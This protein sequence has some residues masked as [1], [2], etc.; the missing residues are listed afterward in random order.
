MHV[1]SVLEAVPHPG[2]KEAHGQKHE[3]QIYPGQRALPYGDI[4][5]DED[6]PPTWNQVV[7]A[8]GNVELQRTAST[9][10]N[11]QSYSAHLG[12]S[13]FNR[14]C[15]TLRRLFVAFIFLDHVV[16]GLAILPF[17]VKR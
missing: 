10:V 16:D 17:V 4:V 15:A 12:L 7:H 8:R 1:L 5:L 9:V 13:A 14:H 2:Q 11:Y 6:A 3:Q